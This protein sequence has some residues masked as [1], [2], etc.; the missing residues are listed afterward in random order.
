MR[1]MPDAADGRGT[2]QLVVFLNVGGHRRL[3]DLSAPQLTRHFAILLRSGQHVKAGAS[4]QV[5]QQS[6]GQVL[7]EVMDAAT[8]NALSECSQGQCMPQWLCH[9]L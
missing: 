7:P 3:A 1:P 6:Q 4:W 8:E 9:C 5:A 2:I